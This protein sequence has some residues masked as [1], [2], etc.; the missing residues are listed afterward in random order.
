MP[1]IRPAIDFIFV[2]SL[3]LALNLTHFL[4][5]SDFLEIS[6]IRPKTPFWRQNHVKAHCECRNKLGIGI[7]HFHTICFHTLELFAGTKESTSYS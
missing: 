2:F 1:H 3:G 5:K 4:A 7:L 6:E